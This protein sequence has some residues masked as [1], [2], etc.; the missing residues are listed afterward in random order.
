MPIYIFNFVGFQFDDS[1]E[2]H[3]NGS[4]I[5]RAKDKSDA[6]KI[7]K[8]FFMSKQPMLNVL[9]ERNFHENGDFKDVVDITE[10]L[11]DDDI[12]TYDLGGHEYD[13]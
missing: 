12:I 6:I 11:R 3:Q 4:L 8:E 5:I 10:V 1:E 13:I 7:F 2:Q 9:I